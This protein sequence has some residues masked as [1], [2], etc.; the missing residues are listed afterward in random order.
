MDALIF[1]DLNSKIKHY[2]R[3]GNKPETILDLFDPKAF[4]QLEDFYLTPKML[5]SLLDYFKGIKLKRFSINSVGG[6]FEFPYGRVQ[7]VNTKNIIKETKTLYLNPRSTKIQIITFPETGYKLTIEGD[8]YYKLE[9][10]QS[11]LSKLDYSYFMEYKLDGN[12]ELLKSPLLYTSN[13]MKRLIFN[14]CDY[15][16]QEIKNLIEDKFYRENIVDEND[17]VKNKIKERKRV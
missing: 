14:E 9:D 10:I 11:F 3:N 17:E 2:I 12:G 1:K 7:V 4:I 16:H 15:F 5:I 6:T 13:Y 8:V